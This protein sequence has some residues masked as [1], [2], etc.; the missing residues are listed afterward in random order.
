MNRFPTLR[1]SVDAV[2][3][4]YDDGS[5]FSR[6]INGPQPHPFQQRPRVLFVSDHENASAPLYTIVMP[7]FEQAST[8]R[9]NL[10][11]IAARASLPHDW[12]FIDDGSSDDSAGV[13]R[14][15][16]EASPARSGALLRNDAPL[17]ETACDNL[18]FSIARTEFVIEIQADIQVLEP[19]FDAAMIA[20][21]RGFPLASSVSGRAGH[22]FAMKRPGLLDRLL[23]RSSPDSIGLTGA[24]V[25]DPSIVDGLR[26]FVYECDTVNRGPWALRK[27]DLESHGYLD[28]A[29]FFLGED[30]HDF[31]RRLLESEQRRPLYVPMRIRST[32]VEGATRRPREGVNAQVYAWM[33][34]SKKG[35]ESYAAFVRG[36]RGR[37]PVRRLAFSARPAR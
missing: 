30:D 33:K 15:F 4:A 2:L 35:S 1:Q 32:L 34:D 3:E 8:L 26:G 12:L 21:L 29:R 5:Y 7:V 27:A 18:G 10:D 6:L 11:L 36:R 31:H 13:A 23:N 25:E 37:S 17:Y 16:L 9:R 22:A 24:Q 28:Q 14:S 20:A 19:E